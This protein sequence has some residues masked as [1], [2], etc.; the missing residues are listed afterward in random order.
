MAMIP[1]DALIVRL[2]LDG[3]VEAFRTLVDRYH[4]D[5]L[6]FATRL[7]GDASDAEDAVQDTFLRAYRYLG[8]YREQDRFRGWLWRI[9]VNRCRTHAGD[10]ARRPELIDSDIIDSHTHHLGDTQDELLDRAFLRQE[11]AR[12]L[13]ELPAEQ[14]EAVVLHFT[15]GLSYPEMAQLTGLGVSALKMRV[16]RA[17]HR[18]RT[19]LAPTHQPAPSAV[20]LPETRRG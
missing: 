6:R 20:P 17:C 10:R 12:A 8:S 9:L 2:V 19:L 3:D 13:A 15:E 16:A 14:R 5:A 4:D 7:L 11:L 18:L 1:S